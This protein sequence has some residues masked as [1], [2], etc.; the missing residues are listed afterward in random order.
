MKKIK[1]NKKS[2]IATLV[3]ASMVGLSFPNVTLAAT[4]PSLGTAA[5]YGVLSS[6]FTRNVGVTAIVGDLGYTTLSGS[7]T[8]TVSGSTIQPAPA[9]AGTDQAAALTALALAAQPCTFTFAPGAIDL[10]S[11]ITH[12]PVGVYTPGVYCSTGAMNIGGGGTITLTGTGTYIFRP[13]GALNSTANSIVAL[14]GASACDVFWT[15]TQ[16]TTLGANSTF[17]GT[18]IDDAGI[19]VGSTVSWI[20]RALAFGG[21]VTTDTDSITVPVCSTTAAV[22]SSGRSYA[23]PPLINVVKVPSPLNL[24]SGQGTVTYTYTV[25]NVGQV[26]LRSVWVKDDK[27]AP[28]NYVSGDRGVDGILDM[29]GKWIFTCTKTVSQTETNTATAHGYANGWDGYDTAIATVAVSTS[30]VATPPLIHLLKKPSVFVLPASG[31]NVTYSYEV[32]NPGTEPLNNVTISDDKCTG[33]PTRVI[34][35]PGDLNANNLLESNEKWQFTCVSSITKTTTNIGTATGRANGFTAVD[36]SPATVV[37]AAPSLPKTG[38]GS[39][40]KSVLWN[41][42][43]P[44]SLI[45]LSFALFFMRRKSIV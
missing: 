16:A 23:P 15:P 35:H 5:T 26:E 17:V 18:V 33:L 30:T 41:V 12:G 42:I 29:Y 8:N 10:A 22:A 3:I 13:V 43:V 2:I 4:T 21:T 39:E 28:V 40:D 34:G 11:D 31:G 14:S 38:F 20:G 37:V 44:V 1:F 19:T 32:T 27:C 24:T 45:A 7:G 25:T 6:T 9:Q 36:F